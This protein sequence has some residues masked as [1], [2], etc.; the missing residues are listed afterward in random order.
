MKDKNANQNGISMPFTLIELLVV[1]AIIAILAALLL[2]ALKRAKDVAKSIACVNNERQLHLCWVNY[3][4]DYDGRLPALTTTVWDGITSSALGMKMWPQ[5]MIDYL[6][7]AVAS[8]GTL[9]A[10]TFLYCPSMDRNTVYFG[11]QYVTYGM[12]HYGIGGWTNAW[13]P[14][15]TPYRVIGQVKNPERQ[16][17]FADSYTSGFNPSVGCW[18]LGSDIGAADFRHSRLCNFVY[19]DGHVEAFNIKIRNTPNIRNSLPFGNP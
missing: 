5:L 12:T 11:S 17:A 9:K 3:I 16:V 18:S 2:P 4:N 6:Y 15:P 19:C 14:T 7:P 8:N 1:I 10:N 13:T